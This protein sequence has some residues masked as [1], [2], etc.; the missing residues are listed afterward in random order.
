[1]GRS[2]LAPEAADL[3]AVSLSS[4][5]VENDSSGNMRMIK[6]RYQQRARDDVAAALTLVAGAFERYPAPAQDLE[7]RRPVVVG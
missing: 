2:A 1:M 3:L 6:R 7:K 4:A 5:M